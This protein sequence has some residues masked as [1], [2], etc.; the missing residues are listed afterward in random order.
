MLLDV[1]AGK[2]SVRQRGFTEPLLC[3]ECEQRLNRWETYFSRV[4]LHPSDSRRPEMLPEDVVIIQGIE[5]EP[6]KLFH[7]SLVWRAGVAQ[8]RYFSS[9]RLRGRA[10][11]LRVALLTADPGEANDFPFWGMALR[12]PKS[13]GWQDEIMKAP[14]ATRLRGQWIHTMIFAGASWHYHTSAHSEGREVPFVFDSSGVL[15]LG[16]RNWKDNPFVK[17]LASKLPI[18]QARRRA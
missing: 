2:Q 7:L 1:Q 14:E 18:K 8:S 15:M 5:Y 4:W 13:G 6:F 3:G 11:A 17:N 16:V 12:D 10:E 9:V